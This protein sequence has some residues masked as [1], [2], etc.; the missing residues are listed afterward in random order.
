MPSSTYIPRGDVPITDTVKSRL[1]NIDNG[2]G[3][4][5]DDV[6]I[7]PATN[8]TLK[9]ARVVYTTEQTGTVAAA[10][11]RVGTAVNGQQIVASTAL[12][13]S[14]AVGTVTALSLVATEVA[15]GTPI[16]VRHTGVAITAAGEYYV[17]LDYVPTH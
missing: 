4:T 1:F 14:K 8:I 16:I 7:R 11:V 12:E 5:L 15:A 2:A 3:A 10:S 9:A 13:N 6:I 17:E